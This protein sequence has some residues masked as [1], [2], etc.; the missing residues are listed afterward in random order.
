MWSKCKG[1]A[2]KTKI[3]N[4]KTFDISAIEIKT[5]GMLNMEKVFHTRT[6]HLK[7]FKL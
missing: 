4:S 1:L 7:L 6:Q 3:N 5:L 2:Q